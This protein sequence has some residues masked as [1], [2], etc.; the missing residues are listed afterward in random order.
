MFA[1]I[2]IALVFVICRNEFYE[3]RAQ[4]LYET[5]Q[6]DD[7]VLIPVRGDD[8]KQTALFGSQLAAAHETGKVVL[9][10]IVSGGDSGSDAATINNDSTEIQH[11]SKQENAQR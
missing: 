3:Q 4:Y 10:D 9:L 2:L 8:N 5:V 6:A 1:S 11:Q 7:H